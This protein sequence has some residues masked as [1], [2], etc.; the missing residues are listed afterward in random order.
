MKQES[1]SGNK[2]KAPQSGAFIYIPKKKAYN[3]Y[4]KK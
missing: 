2:I 1:I 4:Y 3:L